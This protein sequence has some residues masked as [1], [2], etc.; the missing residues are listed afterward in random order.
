MQLDSSTSSVRLQQSRAFY[1]FFFIILFNCR[2][3]C[4][5]CLAK[6]HQL[7]TEEFHNTR[8]GC[9]DYWSMVMS[10][11]HAVELIIARLLCD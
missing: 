6:Q 4:C 9:D 11:V 3:G 1:L 2:V 5:S 7:E 10:H 8:T